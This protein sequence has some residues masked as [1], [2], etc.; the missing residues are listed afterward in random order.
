M[1]IIYV[2]VTEHMTRYVVEVVSQLVV[3]K[4]VEVPLNIK[5]VFV[6]IVYTVKTRAMS[7][8]RPADAFKLI[9]DFKW[10]L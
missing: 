1:F 8:W 7:V 4:V 9:E 6:L 10:N 5:L 3:V 2:R